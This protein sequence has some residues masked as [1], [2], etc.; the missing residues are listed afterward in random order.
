MVWSLKVFIFVA[1]F[2]AFVVMFMS[3]WQALVKTSKKIYVWD[4]ILDSAFI[5]GLVYLV[6]YV[7]FF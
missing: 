1:V 2:F 6:D 7:N 5:I 3:D 4:L